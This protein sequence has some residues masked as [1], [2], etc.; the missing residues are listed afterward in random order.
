MLLGNYLEIVM[1]TAELTDRMENL[2][3]EA[4]VLRRYLRALISLLPNE[5]QINGVL[6]E[7]QRQINID[8]T[9]THGSAGGPLHKAN[10][11]FALNH[12]HRLG[13]LTSR[14]NP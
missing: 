7:T 14:P 11:A 3:A 12:V 10:A 4:L 8:A 1:E 13:F 5:Q 6:Q 2:E 9:A